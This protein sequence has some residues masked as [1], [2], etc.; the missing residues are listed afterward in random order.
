[1]PVALLVLKDERSEPY[2]VAPGIVA[3]MSAETS[4][5]LLVTYVTRQG[6]VGLWPLRL[7]RSDGKSDSWMRTAHEGAN[8]GM[9]RW[10]RLTANLPNGAYDVQVTSANL[11]EPE[12]PDMAFEKR[13]EIAYRDHI[14]ESLD[15]PVLR[16]LRGEI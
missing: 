11:S 6:A 2:L 15:H 13:I 10:V 3:E 12:W 1:M 4:P 8:L 7:P 14:I 16:R 5:H 9:T